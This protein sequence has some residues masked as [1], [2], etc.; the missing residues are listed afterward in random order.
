MVQVVEPGTSKQ[1]VEDEKG[2]VEQKDLIDSLKEKQIDKKIKNEHE[3]RQKQI[4]QIRK[5][6]QRFDSKL[7]DISIIIQNDD[8]KYNLLESSFVD[9]E[10]IKLIKELKDITKKVTEPEEE[11]FKSKS[12]QNNKIQTEPKEARKNEKFGI[13]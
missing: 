12:E 9:E 7:L 6:A 8:S 2:K 3:T 10:L 13:A 4:Q 5:N 1:Q 11:I